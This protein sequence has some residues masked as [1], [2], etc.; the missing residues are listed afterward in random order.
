MSDWWG[1]IILGG[2]WLHLWAMRA[3]MRH[4]YPM[5]D[6]EPSLWARLRGAWKS[7]RS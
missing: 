7:G 4:R 5:P 6:E 1:H 3:W 2:I